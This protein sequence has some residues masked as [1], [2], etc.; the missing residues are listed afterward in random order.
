MN[1]K[2]KDKCHKQYFHLFH[3]VIFILYLVLSPY[4]GIIWMYGLR[5]TKQEIIE[6]IEN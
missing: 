3:E 1:N 5:R 6:F 2:E 4:V